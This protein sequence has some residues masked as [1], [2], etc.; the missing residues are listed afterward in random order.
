M[1]KNILVLLTLVSLLSSIKAN[2]QSTEDLGLMRGN[3]KIFIVMA[4]VLIIVSGLF[5]Y[6]ASIDRKISRLEKGDK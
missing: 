2:A 1:K 3:G 4:V 5:V 6:V